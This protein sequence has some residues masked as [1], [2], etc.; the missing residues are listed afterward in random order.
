MN[1]LINILL[2]VIMLCFLFTSNL[3]SNDIQHT[4]LKLHIHFTD[5]K[6]DGVMV[7]GIKSGSILLKEGLRNGDIILGYNAKVIKSIID[8]IKL[9]EKLSSGLTIK[10]KIKRRGV[11]KTLELS[12]AENV[13]FEIFNSA[14]SFNFK[15]NIPVVL[16]KNNKF[17]YVIAYHDT[18]TIGEGNSVSINFENADFRVFVRLISHLLGKNFAIDPRVKSKITIMSPTT[19]KKTEIY[20]YFL[21]I[22]KLHGYSVIEGKNLSTITPVS[23]KSKSTKVLYRIA[24][25]ICAHTFF[26]LILI[27]LY[28]SSPQIQAIFF[29]NPYVRKIFGLFYIH[30]ALTWIP[31]LRKI[32]F[33]P[34]KDSLLAD[35][36]LHEFDEKIYFSDC[37]VKKRKEK[38]SLPINIA[39]PQIKGQII[40]EGESGLGKSMFLRYLVKKSKRVTIFLQAKKCSSG[41]LKAIQ[42]KLHGVAKDANFLTNLIYSGSVDICIDGLNEVNSDTRS[43]ITQ[44]VEVYFKG[45][46]I[47]ATQPLEWEPPSTAEVFISEPL[48]EDKILN[49]LFSQYSSLACDSKYNEAEFESKCESFILDVIAEENTGEMNQSI[50]LILSNPMDLSIIAQMLSS[51]NEP[52]LFR[53]Q[54]Q[55]FTIMRSDYERIYVHKPFPL[56]EFCEHVYLMKITDEMEFDGEFFQDEL[57]VMERYKIVLSRKIKMEEETYRKKWYFRHEKIMDYFVVQV[58]I[59]DHELPF[60]HIDDPRMRGVYFMLATLLPYDIAMVLRERLIH[61]AAE[62]K[63]HTVSDT[64]VQFL[65]NRE[66][67]R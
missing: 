31:F 65:R 58:F 53:L 12:G 59:S 25:V 56:M 61:Y 20:P 16:N 41:V 5:G 10:V 9:F 13:K 36:H 23:T 2:F 51:G 4:P 34:F 30:F 42:G 39:I 32:L 62:T 46:I 17:E 50:R 38:I 54:E 52:N 27:F 60:K 19:I 18:N 67:A 48:S 55:H 21:R 47:M 40:L 26:W 3:N 8:A 29:W 64:F 7:S 35:A 63:D 15:K 44:F 28:P 24:T 66:K 45:N 33:M 14:H 43:L 11:P 22:A 6:F 37:N 49:F 1:R 57:K